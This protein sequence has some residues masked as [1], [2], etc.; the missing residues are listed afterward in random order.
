MIA[1]NAC[2][3]ARESSNVACSALLAHRATKCIQERKAFWP[4]TQ[5][6]RTA[7][8]TSF[9]NQRVV[10]SPRIGELLASCNW[11]VLVIGAGD[12]QTPEWQG[13]Q[14]HWGK[15]SGSGRIGW[16][17]DITWCNEK[18]SCHRS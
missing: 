9:A 8:V 10:G 2:A 13:L 7:N 1:S 3:Q 12:N 16:C 11:H 6:R 17:F 14:W 18:S 15:S 5:L 4:H